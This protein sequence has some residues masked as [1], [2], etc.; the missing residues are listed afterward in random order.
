MAIPR[1]QLTDKQRQEVIT[2]KRKHSFNKVAEL[3]GIPIGTVRSLVRRNDTAS[4]HAELF[5][6]PPM[7]H[8]KPTMAVVLPERSSVTGNAAL[9]AFMHLRELIKTGDSEVI[10]QALAAAKKIKAPLRDI[11]RAYADYLVGQGK[12]LFAAGMLSASFTDLELLAGRTRARM[13]AL[14]EIWARWGVASVPVTPAD[15]FCIK[16]LDG[17]KRSGVAALDSEEVASR[18]E[19]HPE[20]MPTSLSA[21]LYELNYWDRLSHLINAEC[22]GACISESGAMRDQFIFS[23]LA[24]IRPRS[25]DESSAV[26]GFLVEV[27]RLDRSAEPIIANLIRLD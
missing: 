22:E 4:K 8:N 3:T 12:A 19:R 13:A 15:Q 11:E 9:D 7:T 21:C 6:L 27:D 26:L 24:E 2:L 1:K 23:L 17:F 14:A 20:Y 18:F 10:D 5:T 16:V 25:S